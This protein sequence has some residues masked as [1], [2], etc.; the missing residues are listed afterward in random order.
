[1]GHFGRHGQDGSWSA[2]TRQAGEP[3]SVLYVSD[4]KTV[5]QL[6]MMNLDM[7][8]KCGMVLTLSTLKH[9]CSQNQGRVFLANQNVHGMQ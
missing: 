3:V 4:S 6:P 5:Y 8:C 7:Q 9:L 1:M 2:L